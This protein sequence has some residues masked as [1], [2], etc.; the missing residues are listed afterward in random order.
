MLSQ[1]PEDQRGKNKEVKI[2]KKTKSIFITVK[3]LRMK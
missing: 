3:L 2:K 1:I